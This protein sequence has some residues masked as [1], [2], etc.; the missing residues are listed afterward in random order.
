[1]RSIQY[2]LM[3]MADTSVQNIN[4]NFA[5]Y[6]CNCV[7]QE[8]PVS[9]NLFLFTKG[10][11]VVDANKRLRELLDKSGWTEYFVGSERCF[12]CYAASFSRG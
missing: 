3:K 11:D 9:H 7:E 6:I 4:S 2:T 10:G 1:M 5:N 8:H 12:A